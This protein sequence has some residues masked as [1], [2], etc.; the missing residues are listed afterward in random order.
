MNETRAMFEGSTMLYLYFCEADA[1]N[2][3]SC[4]SAMNILCLVRSV[5]SAIL[6]IFLASFLEQVEQERLGELGQ[7]RLGHLVRVDH[8]YDAPMLDDLLQQ[9]CTGYQVSIGT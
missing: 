1:G 9:R 2:V 4:S 8:L 7:A 6:A 5:N 3:V